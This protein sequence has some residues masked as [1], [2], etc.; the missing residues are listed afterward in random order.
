M[1]TKN[2]K[3]NGAA[4]ASIL[5]VAI[6][7]L[8]AGLFNSCS[9][10]DN[11]GKYFYYYFDQKIFLQQQKDVIFIKFSPGTTREQYLALINSEA[12]LPVR[13]WKFFEHGME[14]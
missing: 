10:D 1:E 3:K 6:V 7:L 11:E 14:N 12:S 2:A 13:E 8:L 9:K 5:R 4:H